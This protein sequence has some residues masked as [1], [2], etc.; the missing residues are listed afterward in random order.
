[1]R[2]ILL[3]FILAVIVAVPAR[4]GEWPEGLAREGECTVC[5][6]RG[7]AHGNEPF[8]AWRAHGSAH[9]GFC[10]EPCADSFDQ[11]PEGYVAP[12]LPRPGPDFEWET[13]TGES[14]SPTGQ[15]LLLVDFWA[16]WCAPCIKTMPALEQIASEF[17]TEGVRVVGVSIDE[18]RGVL[19]SFLKR[20]PL[21]YAVVHD[22]G[23]DP[24]WWQFRV[25]AIPAA[26]LLGPEGRIIAQWS[27]EIE[28]DSLRETVRELLAEGA[29]S[30]APPAVG[31]GAEPGSGTS[32]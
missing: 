28:V 19:D 24:A 13:V 27:G 14:I 5:A 8:V 25:P 16:T 15:T 11:M 22:G 7:A 26:F 6:R 31:S 9:Y 23:D 12:V 2:H 1:M 10:S 29:G 18:D 4:A 20:R 17:A 3:M 21:Q 32:P 30:L